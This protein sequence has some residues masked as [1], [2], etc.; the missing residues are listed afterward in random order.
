M[1]GAVLDSREPR[2]GDFVAYVEQ[3]EREQLARAM[4]PQQ[5]PQ[6]SADGKVVT[7]N[8][9]GGG[10][11]ALSPTEAQRLLQTLKAPGNAGSSPPRGAMIGVVIGAALVAFGLMAEGAMLLVLLGAVLLW[12]NLRRLRRA[13]APAST[14]PAQQV[15][16]AFGPKPSSAVTGKRGA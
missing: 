15:D 8:A 5:L 13:A 4:Q 14:P 9:S 7:E 6:L 2:R 1:S 16:R 11:R 12:H 10:A 3:I